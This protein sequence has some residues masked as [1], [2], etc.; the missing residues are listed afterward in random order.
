MW[1]IELILNLTFFRSGGK[2]PP[3]RVIIILSAVILVGTAIAI[4]TQTSLG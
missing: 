3:L 2:G 1:I 4:I